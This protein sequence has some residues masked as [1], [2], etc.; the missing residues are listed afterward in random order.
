MGWGRE[1]SYRSA[2]QWYRVDAALPGR[3]RPSTGTGAFVTVPATPEVPGHCPAGPFACA[4]TAVARSG[5]LDTAA[6][7]DAES[8]CGRA[9]SAYSWT[10][11]LV[12]GTNFS[13]RV[14]APKITTA[15]AALTRATLGDRTARRKPNGAKNFQTA[16]GRNRRWQIS[17]S[18][19]K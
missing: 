11:L 3:N 18:Q 9:E 10:R 2:G 17:Q 14:P 19:S 7:I 6:C 12:E 5:A 13:A 16:A 4:R 8:S 15:E 1:S